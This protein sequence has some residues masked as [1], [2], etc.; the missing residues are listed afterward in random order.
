MNQNKV[1][2]MSELLRKKNFVETLEILRAELK[3]LTY[4]EKLEVLSDVLCE[5]WYLIDHAEFIKEVLD[6]FADSLK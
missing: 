6:V 4:E 2:D 5:E 1:D 3:S